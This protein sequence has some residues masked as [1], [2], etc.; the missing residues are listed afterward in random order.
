MTQTETNI[1]VLNQQH[2]QDF[3]YCGQTQQPVGHEDLTLV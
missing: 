2:M 3:I 1:L